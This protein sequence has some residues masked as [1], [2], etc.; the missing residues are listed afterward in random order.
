MADDGKLRAELDRAHRAARLL[1]DDLF[2]AAVEGIK[3]GLWR[4]FSTSA[5]DDD[6]RRLHI[7]LQLGLLDD[8]LKHIRRHVETGKL[9]SRQLAQTGEKRRLW[10]K[11]A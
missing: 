11:P 7:R 6:R 5:L 2:K 9:A 1:D 10:R 3:D 8:L 4:E